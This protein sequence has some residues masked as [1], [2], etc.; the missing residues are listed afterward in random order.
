ME[1]RQVL[2]HTG[3]LIVSVP[4]VAN[5]TVRLALLLGRL[6]YQD[7]GILDCTHLRFY[8]RHTAQELLTRARYKIVETR[9]SV[10]PLE[11]LLGLSPEIPIMR[12]ANWLLRV[13]TKLMPALFGYQVIMVPR[14]MKRD[15]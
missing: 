1:C 5:L 14:A 11:L 4:N 10:I 6:Y 12:A 9:I 2:R 8:T 7:R 13:I 15:S 3:Q